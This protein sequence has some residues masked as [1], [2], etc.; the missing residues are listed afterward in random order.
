MRRTKAFHKKFII[1]IPR[2]NFYLV[3]NTPSISDIAA[4]TRGFLN[5]TDYIPQL[6]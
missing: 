6:S 1:K 3:T 4:H 5:N 2:N